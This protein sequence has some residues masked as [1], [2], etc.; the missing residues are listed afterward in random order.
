MPTN[1]TQWMQENQGELEA[2]EELVA[3]SG[4]PVSLF[5]ELPRWMKKAIAD[6]LMISFSQPYWAKIAEATSDQAT[7]VLL[8]GIARGDSI[9]TM[10]RAMQSSFAGDTERYARIRSRN[11]ARTEAA[12]ALNGARKIGMQHVLDGP[13]VGLVSSWLSVL[14]NTTR[15]EHAMLDGEPADENGNW[16]LAGYDIPWPGH[17]SLPPAQRCNCQ[18]S[19]IMLPDTRG[20]RSADEYCWNKY[21][22]SSFDDIIADITSI[23]ASSSMEVKRNTTRA[24]FVRHIRLTEDDLADATAPVIEAS[25]SD[26]AKNL[27]G[28]PTPDNPEP[29]AIDRIVQTSFDQRKWTEELINESLP[30]VATRMAE[31]AKIQLAEMQRD[32]PANAPALV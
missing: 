19:I 6:Q 24:A 11:I 3:S 13:D 27:R 26:L 14:G 21:A 16:N 4:L 22:V 12:N 9:S 8:D 18:C 5:T 32:M 2:L 25:I 1:A 29:A 15:D 31:A 28:Q 7:R 20:E 30:V 23:V 17:W 10:A